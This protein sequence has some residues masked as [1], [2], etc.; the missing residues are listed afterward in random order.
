MAVNETLLFIGILIGF[1]GWILSN[2]DV[3]FGIIL[4]VAGVVLFILAFFISPEEEYHPGSAKRKWA[5]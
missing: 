4:M 3:I 5:D 1:F 2:L